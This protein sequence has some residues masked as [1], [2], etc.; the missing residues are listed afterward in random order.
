MVIVQFFEND[1]KNINLVMNFL[2]NSFDEIHSLLYT[3]NDKENDSIYDREVKLFYG[4][5]YIEEKINSLNS[6]F[7]LNLF[8][9]RIFI[10]LLSYMSNSKIC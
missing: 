10:K 7:I 1:K 2:K 9:K 4:K 5:N 3:V 8:F 6:K